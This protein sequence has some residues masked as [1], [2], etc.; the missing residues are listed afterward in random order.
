[1]A[2]IKCT[3]CGAVRAYYGGVRTPCPFC[4]PPEDPG[5]PFENGTLAS[6]TYLE[7][8]E[9]NKAADNTWFPMPGN[10]LAKVLAAF[11]QIEAT[12]QDERRKKILALVSKI[13][14]T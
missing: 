12:I 11:P 4:Y 7:Y 5:V 6:L 14:M 9:Q 10:C 8:Q 1:M 2:A 3:Q 13:E